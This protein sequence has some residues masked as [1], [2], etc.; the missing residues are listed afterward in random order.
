MQFTSISCLHTRSFQTPVPLS[1]FMIFGGFSFTGPRCRCTIP[2]KKKKWILLS[3][4]QVM[5]GNEIRSID[6]TPGQCR[7]YSPKF[8][9]KALLNFRV[10]THY[11]FGLGMV[12]LQT[13]ERKCRATKSEPLTALGELI[14]RFPVL[15]KTLPET[16][17]FLFLVFALSLLATNSFRSCLC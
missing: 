7:K 14:F 9:L 12:I 4:L 16:L 1:C 17:S 10:P 13:T 11:L 8:G 2:A 5:E 3:G 15:A 6:C